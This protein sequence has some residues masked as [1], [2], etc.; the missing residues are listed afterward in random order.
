MD[1]E[2]VEP[3]Q[4]IRDETEEGIRDATIGLEDLKGAL[5]EEEFVGRNRRPRR[6][7][8]EVI[9]EKEVEGWDVLGT[10]AETVQVGGGRFFV[11]RSRREESPKHTPREEV[12]KVETTV[13]DT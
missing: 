13:D 9:R 3:L 1:T 6:K 12:A 5:K 11:V 8:G 7:R 10:A 4:S 2:G